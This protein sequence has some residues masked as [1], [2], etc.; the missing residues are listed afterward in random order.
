MKLKNKIGLF[1]TLILTIVLVV[2]MWNGELTIRSDQNIDITQ[3]SRAIEMAN[4]DL[5]NNVEIDEGVTIETEKVEPKDLVHEVNDDEKMQTEGALEEGLNIIES[6]NISSNTQD[7]IESISIDANKKQTDSNTQIAESKL[8]DNTELLGT[9]LNKYVLHVIS[10]YPIGTNKYPY[11]LNNDYANYNGVTENIYYKGEILAKGHPSGIKYSHCSGITF[12]VL[13]KA[14]QARNKALGISPDN[15]NNMNK[16]QL[17]DFLLTWY[18]A[19]GPKSQSNIEV[20][21]EKY[22][23]GKRITNLEN[24]IRGD[25]ID[26]SRTNNTGHTVVFISWIKEGNNI[27]GIKYWS[28]QQSTNGIGYNE[29]YFNVKRSNGKIGSVI[30]SSVYIARVF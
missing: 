28:S 17:F 12:E 18:A 13:Y 2:T 1:K 30:K 21:V 3:S 20:A 8:S 4:K 14:M 23:L 24:A 27:V 11:L 15:F 26:I 7:T 6:A 22:G 25:F 9:N 10:T 5:N 16:D 19:T 29:E